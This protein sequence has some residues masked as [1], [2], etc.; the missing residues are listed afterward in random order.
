MLH[1]TASWDAVMTHLEAFV[2]SWSGAVPPALADHLPEGPP[3]V[4]QR[5][6]V[7]LVK[8]DI[9]ERLRAG[10]ARSV[11]DYC[12][13]HPELAAND[14]LLLEVIHEDFQLRRRCGEAV[15][16]SAYCDRHPRLADDIRR[17]AGRSTARRRGQRAW[18]RP[19]AFRSWLAGKRSTISCS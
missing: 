11:D 12:R 1:D 17:C 2:H 19:C 4:R 9:D 14:A 18:R 6:L 8:A 13:D 5:V 7:E 15:T 3:G 10:C 16:V